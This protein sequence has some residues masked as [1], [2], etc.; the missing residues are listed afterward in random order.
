MP[1]RISICALLLALPTAATARILDVP[2]DH[3]RIQDAIEASSDGD[4]VLVQPGT[5]LETLDLGA[6]AITVTG[7]APADSAVVAAT[8]V[9]AAGAGLV[10]VFSGGEGSGSVLAGLRL[11]GGHG[12]FGGGV[13]CLAAS[14]TFLHCIIDGNTAD[15]HGGGAYCSNASPQFVSCRIADNSATGTAF[16]SGGGAYCAGG[17]APRFELTTFAGNR[18]WKNGGGLALAD[19]SFAGIDGCSLVRNWAEEDGGAVF[20]EGRS[21]CSID[22][23]RLQRNRADSDGGALHVTDKAIL[24]ATFTTIS[25]G[26]AYDDG[27]ALYAKA[28]SSVS[29]TNCTLT[30]NWA[31]DSG[32]AVY[33]RTT[34]GLRIESCVLW[35]DLPAEIFVQAGTVDVKGSDVQGGW[36][37]EE[38]FDEDPLFCDGGC[39]GE[40]LGVGDQSPCLLDGDELVGALERGCTVPRAHAPV[41]WRV[42]EQQPTIR[43]A[44]RVACDGDT[45][46]L[47]P[48]TYTEHG[49]YLRRHSVKLLGTDPRDSTTVAETVMDGAGAGRPLEFIGL[50]SAQ[51][52]ISGITV[53]HGWGLRGGGIQC[54]DGASIEIDR[55]RLIDNR[56]QG[57]G[58]IEIRSSSPTITHSW[59]E[60]NDASFWAGAIAAIES[61]PT[62]VQCRFVA[63]SS[64]ADAGGALLFS[65]STG[66]LTHCVFRDNVS[67]NSGAVE[68]VD[69]SDPVIANCLM[70]GN[71]ADD[72]GA[73]RISRE[74]SP[75]IKNCTLVGNS[76][77]RGGAI[78]VNSDSVPVL[79][80]CILWDNFPEAIHDQLQLAIVRYSDV[81]GGW[82]GVANID[83]DPL[84]RSYRSLD[85]VLAPGSPCI[86]AGD[87]TRFDQIHD[88]HPKWPNGYRNGARSDMGAY[89]G[90]RN[91]LWVTGD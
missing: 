9:D 27:G 5:Y 51:T 79:T 2:G 10:A 23:S 90:P 31:S 56:A 37:G 72:G 70:I 53:Q 88:A 67:Y 17:S 60:N 19:S 22:A 15:E 85:H 42:P 4:S 87:P 54:I 91:A 59:F 6:R 63:N 46:L 26:R 33:G 49:I 82:P 12:T 34:G 71:Y 86:D 81:E 7:T 55:C 65:Q 18:A 44:F 48:G 36:P 40:D 21:S 47:S 13:H 29:L 52:V 69:G 16:S 24:S 32:G 68:I 64:D 73:M 30:R 1:S 20:A 80:N 62:I 38:N 74:A 11:T 75:W 78:R 61:S 76:G 57:G 28:E 66:T 3:N 45:I 14:P 50:G 43:E 35:E 58:A 89:G 83:S 41:E 39:G 8:V 77:I 84:F 25:D